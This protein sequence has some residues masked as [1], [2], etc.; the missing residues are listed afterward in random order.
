ML[1]HPITMKTTANLLAASLCAPVLLFLSA[2]A[3]T[4]A[5][6]VVVAGLA[7]IFVSDYGQAVEPSYA[8]VTVAATSTIERLPLAA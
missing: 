8:K 2:S 5:S 7:A 4:A 1:T 6:L 3:I